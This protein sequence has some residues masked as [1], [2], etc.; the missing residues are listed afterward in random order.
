M[1]WQ[2]HNININRVL[3]HLDQ[4]L[5]NLQ[6][7]CESNQ[8][9]IDNSTTAEEFRDGWQ[10]FTV[11]ILEFIRSWQGYTSTYNEAVEVDLAKLEEK[12]KESEELVNKYKGLLKATM[13]EVKRLEEQIQNKEIVER[14]SSMLDLVEEHT[15]ALALARN[16]KEQKDIRG[17]ASHRFNQSVKTSDLV[18]DYISSGYKVTDELVVKYNMTRPGLIQRLKSVGIYKGRT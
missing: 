15:K 6:Q 14:A 3:E 9:L 2:I 7:L 18:N 17:E 11:N 16:M 10:L 8:V 4:H 5:E 1:S 12:L 13:D